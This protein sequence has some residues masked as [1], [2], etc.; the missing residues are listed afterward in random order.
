MRSIVPVLEQAALV[1]GVNPCN[2][3]DLGSKRE[4]GHV[5]PPDA[6][7]GASILSAIRLPAG[8]LVT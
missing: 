1:A 8:S 6:L 2:L 4:H 7:G 5:S 3:P